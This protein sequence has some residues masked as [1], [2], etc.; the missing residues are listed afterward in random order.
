MTDAAHIASEKAGPAE[1][2]S[3]ETNWHPD[4]RKLMAYWKTIRPA[5]D[6]LPGRQHLDPAR[7]VPL[8]PGNWLLDVHRAPFRL[9]YRITGTAVVAS[10]GRT[11]TGLWFDEPHR[12]MP[13]GYLLRYQSVPGRT[14]QTWQRGEH[15][16]EYGTHAIQARSQ[17]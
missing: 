14:T 1:V 12:E 3:E 4:I 5:P 17:G 8:L 2:A 9:R 13:P 16:M 11:L 7:I 15:F 10:P 6:L